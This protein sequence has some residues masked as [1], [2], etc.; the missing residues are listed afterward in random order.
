MKCFEINSILNYKKLNKLLTV[1][2]KCFEIAKEAGEKRE[3]AELTVNMKCFE[4]DEID[5][6][7]GKVH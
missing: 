1:N 4:I 3:E 7:R 2:M 6:L 5:R